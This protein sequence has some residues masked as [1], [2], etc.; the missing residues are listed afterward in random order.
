[1]DTSR[2]LPAISERS[3]FLK[4]GCAL[5]CFRSSEIIN[6]TR[7]SAVD[8]NMWPS[9]AGAGP[10]LMPRVVIICQKNPSAFT[11]QGR[12]PQLVKGHNG[13]DEIDQKILI[14]LQSRFPIAS[15]PMPKAGEEL[16]LLEQEA[17]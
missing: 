10:G 12:M 9:A 5:P 4:S 2:F 1:M 7:E 16:G 14:L 3:R 17:L 11:N 15:R 6:F 8:V 13:S